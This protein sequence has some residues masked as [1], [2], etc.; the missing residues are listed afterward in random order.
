M[1]ND[2]AT[3]DFGVTYTPTEI[4]INNQELLKDQVKKYADKY[5]GWSVITEESVDG[6][7]LVRTD[8]NRMKKSFDDKRKEIKGEYNKPLKKFESQ[9]KDMTSII[10]DVLGPLDEGI[11]KIEENQRQ[12]RKENVLGLIA[13]IAAGYN[14]DPAEVQFDPKWTNKSITKKKLTDQITDSVKLLQRQHKAYEINKRLIEE[15]CKIKKIDPAGWIAQLSNERDAAEIIDS[16]D[17]FL[18]D[19][20]KQKIAEQKLAE[21][22]KAKQEALQQKIGGK[23]INT[24]TGEVVDDKPS[25][26]TVSIKLTGTQAGIIQAMQQV[27]RFKDSFEVST[28][29]IEKMSEV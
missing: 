14:I 26:Y 29:V 18:I 20:E 13:E 16:I 5:K 9:V 22:E 7:K 8:L 4:K 23:V 2:L 15:H 17:Q 27:N 6:D 19:Q 11:K 12:E 3:I 21:A 28:E 25:E 24:E 10:D 1:A